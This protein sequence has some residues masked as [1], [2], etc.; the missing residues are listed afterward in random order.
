[1]KKEINGIQEIQRK[2]KPFIK[3][4]IETDANTNVQRERDI[5]LEH[6]YLDDVRV[7]GRLAPLGYLYHLVF[8]AF[9]LH[10]LI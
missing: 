1:M 4:E 6:Q 10:S 5:D 8:I 9:Y 7:A 3:R 2:L